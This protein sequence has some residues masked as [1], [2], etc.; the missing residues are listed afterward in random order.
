MYLF[1]YNIYV[2]IYIYTFLNIV[3]VYRYIFLNKGYE[4]S[5]RASSFN[6]PFNTLLHRGIPSV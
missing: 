1:H 6:T 2:Y 5:P 3:Q 4:A